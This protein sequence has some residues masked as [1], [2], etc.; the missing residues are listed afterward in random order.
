MKQKVLVTGGSGMVGSHFRDNAYDF[1]ILS[2]NQNE[3][4]ITSKPS[5]KQYLEKHNP[6]WIINFAAFTDVNQA[7]GERGNQNGQSWKI[8]VEGVDNLLTE[9]KSKNFVQISTDMVFEGSQ[10]NPGPYSEDS[11]TPNDYTN[12]TWY[13]WTKNR[14][15]KI[16]LSG[17]GSLVRIIYPVR[18]SFSQKLD[19]IRAPL[20]KIATNKMHPLFADQQISIS[21]INEVT[22]S[23]RTII[24]ND[25]HGIFHVSSDTTTPLDLIAKVLQEL[26]ESPKQLKS[27]SVLE[28][29]KTNGPSYRYPVYGGLKSQQTEDRL[30]LHFSTWQTIVENLVSTGLKLPNQN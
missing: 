10:T 29:L 24:Q 23:L 8:N 26:G 15:E 14:A 22:E 27:S 16:V 6:D 3:L 19:Y 12:L 20:M 25:Q 28:F 13:G 18:A 7:E 9:F 5:V 17:G 1:S 30:G 4:D 21:Y 11:K 2:P